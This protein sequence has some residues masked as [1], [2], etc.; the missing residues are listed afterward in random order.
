M[1]TFTIRLIMVAILWSLWSWTNTTE[2][3]SAENEVVTLTVKRVIVHEG[4]LR[5]YSEISNSSSKMIRIHSPGSPAN[6]HSLTVVFVEGS[7]AEV[8]FFRN[9]DSVT[10]ASYN[11]VT[12]KP[13]DVFELSIDLGPPQWGRVVLPNRGTA[14]KFYVE[15]NSPELFQKD[16]YWFGRIESSKILIDSSLR[17]LFP[18]EFWAE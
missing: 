12:L 15:F 6:Q 13:N 17:E 4:R 7:G 14:K 16:G 1:V 11:F 5:I 2:A 8:R 3:N 10:G 18:N 9:F